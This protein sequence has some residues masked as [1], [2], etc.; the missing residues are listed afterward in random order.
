MKNYTI[1]LN[2]PQIKML[3]SM[4]RDFDFSTFIENNPEIEEE[5]SVGWYSDEL[6]NL[7]WD[8]CDWDKELKNKK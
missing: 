5:E 1:E 8:I 7:F 2:E 6:D 4:Y 3:A